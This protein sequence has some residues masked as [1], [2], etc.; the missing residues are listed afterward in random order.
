MSKKCVE[1]E[2]SAGAVVSEAFC[3]FA[4]PPPPPSKHPGAVP[5]LTNS[6]IMHYKF[7]ACMG[8]QNV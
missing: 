5:V 3:H 4:P 8:Q 1:V 6:I 2:Q 7:D